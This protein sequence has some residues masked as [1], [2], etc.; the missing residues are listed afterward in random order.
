MSWTVPVQKESSQDKTHLEEVLQRAVA[1]NTPMFCSCPDSGQF[2]SKDYPTAYNRD[3]FFRIG[4]ANDDGSVFRWTENIDSLDFILPGV[5]V[6][7]DHAKKRLPD[8]VK[9][10]RSDTGS[11]VATALAAGLA[12][13]IIC[14]V[15]ASA[16][17]LLTAGKKEGGESSELLKGISPADADR[18]ATH[19]NMKQ[20]FP[21]LGKL[22][23][24]RFIPVWE[25]FSPVN[26]VFKNDFADPKK[27]EVLVR[28]VMALIPQ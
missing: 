24:K 4:A 6:V 25:S 17:G 11:S 23:D 10:I 5:D 12:A 18:I 27:L 28:F 20:A 22:T 3:R 8:R 1:S 9:D 13:T 15:K 16:M 19:A 26:E 2:T 14:C 21:K 7:R